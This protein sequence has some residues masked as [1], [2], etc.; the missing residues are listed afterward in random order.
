MCSLSADF[1]VHKVRHTDTKDVIKTATKNA[2]LI[3]AMGS[4]NVNLSKRQLKRGTEGQ[5]I[6]MA[7]DP[8]ILLYTSDFLIGVSFMN[9]EERGQYITL[10]C[11]QHQKGHMSLGDME[12]S[13][14]KIHKSVMSHFIKD[15][16]GLYYNK[17]IEEEI[18]KR[19]EYSESRRR[20]RSRRNISASHNSH[21]KNIC[22]SYDE[23]MENENE[24]ENVDVYVDKNKDKDKDKDINDSRKH[25]RHKYGEYKNVL[26]SDDDMDKLKSEFPDWEE[27]IENLSYYIASS[28]RKYADHLATIRCWARNDTQNNSNQQNNC[29]DNVFL[30]IAKEEGIV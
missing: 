29:G 22:E 10:L 21:M 4:S 5:V 18:I 25:V 3:V 7:K 30:A 6:I 13:V 28:G 11:L 14:G 23:H 1:A 17:R 19:R 8:A 2:L 15:E 20:N 12:M 27:R 9:M 16:D 24:N 26:L